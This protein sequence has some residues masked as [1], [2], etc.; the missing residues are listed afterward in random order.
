MVG[1]GGNCP[2]NET[3]EVDTLCTRD[4]LSKWASRQIPGNSLIMLVSAEGLTSTS[5]INGL[6]CIPGHNG[7]SDGKGVLPAL[8]TLPC[9]HSFIDAQGIGS[10]RRG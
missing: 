10:P 9:V 4:N 6:K 2:E 5:E 8:S 1:A 3:P 7:A